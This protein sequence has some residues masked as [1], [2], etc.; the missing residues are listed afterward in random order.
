MVL[1][2]KVSSTVCA[3]MIAVKITRSLPSPLKSLQLR[4]DVPEIQLRMATLIQPLSTLRIAIRQNQI[5]SVNFKAA[6]CA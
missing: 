6:S 1:S 3:A 4:V 2:K 5:D